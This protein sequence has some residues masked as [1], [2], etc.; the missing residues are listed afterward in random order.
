ME[1]LL[2][3]LNSKASWTELNEMLSNKADKETVTNAMCKKVNKTDLSQIEQEIHEKIDKMETSFKQKL[4][5]VIEAQEKFIKI[6][7]NESIFQKSKLARHNKCEEM[8][9]Q[10]SLHQS[11]K[12]SELNNSISAVKEDISSSI[13]ALSSNVSS[14]MISFGKKFTLLLESTLDSLKNGF[15]KDLSTIEKS[16]NSSLEKSNEELKQ[17]IEKAQDSYKSTVKNLKDDLDGLRI[18]CDELDAKINKVQTQRSSTDKLI[19]LEVS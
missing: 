5:Q 12:E 15:N 2:M 17:K 10:L 4:E 6:V 3:S 7:E 18:T 19:K 14:N 11:Q 9:R 8:I 16:V 1:S 13:R